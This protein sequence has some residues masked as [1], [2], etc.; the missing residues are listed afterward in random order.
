MR[1]RFMYRLLVLLFLSM[2]T[3]SSYAGAKLEQ[4]SLEIEGD[5]SFKYAGFLTA[6]QKGY[7]RDAGLGVHVRLSKDSAKTLLRVIETKSDYALTYTSVPRLEK[8]QAPVEVVAS[9]LPT[10]SLV[11][12]GAS[13]V[14]SVKELQGKKIAGEKD[15]IIYSSVG[16]MLKQF[17]VTAENS[18]FVFFDNAM[19]SFI[20]GD[21]DGIVVDMS[22][23]SMH[24]LKQSGKA[25]Q[26][27]YPK[28]YGFDM[29]GLNLYTHIEQS[30]K[31]RVRTKTF[32]EATMK[33]WA[34]AFAHKN[35]V[36]YLL[37]MKNPHIP[38]RAFLQEA[39]M[40]QAQMKAKHP[41]V[42]HEKNKRYYQ[43]LVQSN[44][45]ID[46]K[47]TRS[48]NYAWKF[49]YLVLAFAGMLYYLYNEQKM[50][51]LRLEKLSTTDKLTQLYNRLR[52][53]ELLDTQE[54]RFIRYGERCSV[55]IIDIDYFKQVN[56]TF[57]HNVG[58]EVLKEFSN[59][60]LQNIRNTDFLGR[61]G[62]EEFM[63]ICPNSTVKS[64]RILA[65]KL[66]VKVE[67][68]HFKYIGKKTASFGIAEYQKKLRS[69]DVIESADTNLYTAKRTGRNRVCC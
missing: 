31:E 47:R 35:E 32:I 38:Q 39:N 40:I 50:N 65:E 67:S 44:T 22:T 4:I 3:T 61:W 28:S 12:F 55:I 59:I 58:D 43:Q 13:S 51:V 36:S 15:H 9:F 20:H 2:L 48:T 57:G 24:T 7:Y 52:M 37:S 18:Q 8:H 63:V 14:S 33:G 10:S 21:V 29:T 16:L 25:Y 17:N 56:D 54:K 46:D 41:R 64:A 69:T 1:M 19:S 30:S 27:F 5:Y 45:L 34:Y 23:P 26:T 60:L 62:G 68:H 49:L 6:L 53:D 42:Y 11:L 66:R